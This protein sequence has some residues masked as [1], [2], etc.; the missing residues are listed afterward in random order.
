MLKKLTAL[1]VH[2]AA[3]VPVEDIVFDPSLRLSCEQNYCGNFGA[4]Y[5]CPPD[6]GN[7]ED[8]IQKA[9]G[10]KTALVFQT[11]G[12]IEDSF[13]IEGMGEVKRRHLE[14]STEATKIVK[15]A[16]PDCMPL[17]AGGCMICERCGKIDG[18]PC[19]HPED[20][21]PS[22]ESYGIWVSK[23]A[24]AAG[25]KYINGQNTVTYFGAFL[26]K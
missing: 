24:E 8:L 23:L 26:I 5:M 21:V 11:V 2:R 6:I 3:F 16:Y 20:A 12:K 18:V 9:R 19:R 7:V 14:I 15:K 17:G 25:M 22:L 13:D 4:N 1:G 10:Y